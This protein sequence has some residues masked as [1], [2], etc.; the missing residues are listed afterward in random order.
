MKLENYKQKSRKQYKL[1][2]YLLENFFKLHEVKLTVE[3]RVYIVGFFYRYI[4]KLWTLPRW[5]VIAKHFYTSLVRFIFDIPLQVRKSL[6]RCR[7]FI[8]W[9]SRCYTGIFRKFLCTILLKGV[10]LNNLSRLGS[11]KSN[12]S[13]LLTKYKFVRIFSNLFLVIVVS[14]VW[15]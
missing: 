1:F 9:W 11:V 12:M 3:T 4:S 14:A 8:S 6:G 7:R 5:E 13:S 10:I 2:F 15:S